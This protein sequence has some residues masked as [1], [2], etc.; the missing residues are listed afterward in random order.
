[1]KGRQQHCRFVHSVAILITFLPHHVH[2]PSNRVFSKKRTV[3]KPLFAIKHKKTLT[4][5]ESLSCFSASWGF[6]SPHMRTFYRFTF[7]LRWNTASSLKIKRGRKVSYSM[8]WSIRSQ[9]STHFRLSFGRRACTRCRRYSL[10]SKRR[11]STR[12]TVDYGIPSSL[13]ALR[14]D[15][16]GLLS[17]RSWIRLTFSSDTRVR[18]ELLPLHRQP[19]FSNWWFQRQMLVLV[20]GWILKRR[21]NARCTAVADSVL[22]LWPRNWTFK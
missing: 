5:G 9:N 8:C 15:L 7:P 11:L 17:K 2:Y 21:R 19:I 6:Y 16:H 13:L 20:G 12:Q 18:P 14:V 3:H 4:L 22:T 10:N 1:V